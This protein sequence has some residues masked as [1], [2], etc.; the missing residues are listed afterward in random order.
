[1]Y[2]LRVELMGCPLPGEY[3]DGVGLVLV[4][5]GAGGA[6]TAAAGAGDDYACPGMQPPDW[7]DMQMVR[8]K[9]SS[10]RATT[11]PH[12]HNN[13]SHLWGLQE[14]LT[15][16]PRLHL[17]VCLNQVA[18]TLSIHACLHSTIH[19]LVAADLLR[20]FHHGCRPKRRVRRC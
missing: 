16:S 7:A 15:T 8:R 2:V 9:T 19:S 6:A 5:R 4:G 1:M 13:P 18:P 14:R 10:K 3:S 11:P 17:D 12:F 20:N